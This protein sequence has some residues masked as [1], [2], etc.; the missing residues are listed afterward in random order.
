MDHKSIVIKLGGTSQCKIAYDNLINYIEDLLE[1]SY[2]VYI[3]LSAVSGVTNL[4]DRYTKTKDYI[5]IIDAIEYNEKLLEELYPSHEYTVNPDKPQE[6][7]DEFE[8]KL[9]NLTDNYND[10]D[11]II[12]KAKIIGYGEY[13]ST[14]IFNHYYNTITIN[15][16]AMFMNSYDYIKTSKKVYELY[17][18]VEF[19]CDEIINHNSDNDRNTYVYIF[20]GF[21]ASDSEI[22][23]T[24]LG[25][26]GSDTTGSLIA[27]RVKAERYEVWTDVD[28][29]YT[30]DPR[31]S[32]SVIKIKN[33]SYNVCKEIA[34]LG[35]KVMHPLSIL[36]CELLGIPIIVKSSFSDNDGTII[37]NINDS[38]KIIAIQSDITL[39]NIRSENMWNAYGFVADIFRRF[40]EL[41]IDINIITTSQF[42]ISTTTNEKNKYLLNRVYQ[43]FES[44]YECDMTTGCTIISIISDDIYSDL[45]KLNLNS[46]KPEIVHIGSNNLSVNLV[47]KNKTKDEIKELINSI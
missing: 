6:L 20:Q 3:V 29:I 1:N 14:M 44:E 41:H 37:S 26:G 28:G 39:F 12:S 10:L 30:A 40:S 13:M 9:K 35:A 32:N 21:I 36:P 31:I 25:R 4:L 34:A 33:I 38:N 45:N 23:P 7:L 24:L 5:H 46:L 47:F 17:P 22:K 2:N 27:K 11:D 16:K 42:S 18:A 8:K 43:Q 15:K 19:Y